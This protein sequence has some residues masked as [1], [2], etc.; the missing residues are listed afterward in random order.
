MLLSLSLCVVALSVSMCV[1]CWQRGNR[2][3]HEWAC[4]V[5]VYFFFHFSFSGIVSWL[6]RL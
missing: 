5:E 1:A 2:V 3:W 4:C 6:F